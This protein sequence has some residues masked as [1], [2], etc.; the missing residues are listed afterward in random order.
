MSTVKRSFC[1]LPEVASRG[2]SSRDTFLAMGKF[3]VGRFVGKVMSVAVPLVRVVTATTP[4]GALMQ[5]SLAV[6]D[7]GG[8][9]QE[10]TFGPA[11]SQ[12]C[13]SWSQ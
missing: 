6:I 11:C 2:A 7:S 3:K 1:S 4:I 8:Q 12:L 5:A 13:C 10:F 9:N